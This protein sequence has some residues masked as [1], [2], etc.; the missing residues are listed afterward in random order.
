[1]TKYY[2]ILIAAIIS[3]LLITWVINI[4]LL[5][6]EPAPKNTQLKLDLNS[7]IDIA[8]KSVAHLQTVVAFQQ[9]EKVGRQARV[10]RLCM[11]D[12]AY[13]QNTEW[14]QIA[15]Q[16]AKKNAEKKGISFN[17][18]FENLRREHMILYDQ[19]KGLPAFWVQAK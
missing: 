6:E 4:G 14:T 9:L 18:A 11:K 8:E 19:P 5:D 7:C 15:K 13:Q 10:M 16:L 3:A 17:E 12:H 2:S 1:M